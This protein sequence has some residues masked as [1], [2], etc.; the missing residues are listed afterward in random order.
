MSGG[1][2]GGS[3]IRRTDILS[4]SNL[5]EDGRKPHEIRRMRVQIGP[6]SSSSGDVG[7]GGS[8]SVEMGLTSVLASA[9][10][11]IE[12]RRRS[13][14]LIDR[15]V[16]EVS[17]QTAPFAPAGGDRRT[18]NPNTD[19]R[20]IELSHLV[21]KAVEAAVLLHLH[22]KSRIVVSIAVLADDGGRL[23]AAINAASLALIDAGIPTKDFVCACSA[24]YAGGTG[25]GGLVDATTL[26]DLNRREESSGGG[27]SSS[28]SSSAYLPCAILPQRG[29]V[30]LAQCESRLPDYDATERVLEA[31][32]DGCLAVYQ[33]MQA[34][35]RE[36]A[37]ALL[38]A[39]SGR[40]D[41]RYSFS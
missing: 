29:T 2:G 20:L 23:C 41:L 15:A 10:G 9:R 13:D 6:L 35:V 34:S 16:V 38:A 28:S 14:E 7:G 11:P 8:A 40:A 5:R 17:V 3:S 39:R 31:A 37:A 26:V 22:P 18:N 30:V 1:F 36:R 19:R 4:L 33:I 24:G 32:M 12:C 21:K 27:Q 25:A